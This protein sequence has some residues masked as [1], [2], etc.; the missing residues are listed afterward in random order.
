MPEDLGEIGDKD[1]ADVVEDEE[2]S[3]CQEKDRACKAN[4]LR[5][6]EIRQLHEY[7]ES[8][9]KEENLVYTIACESL[10][11]VHGRI[12]RL[13]HYG[14]VAIERK[15]GQ[16]WKDALSKHNRYPVVD[17]KGDKS[18]LHVQFSAEQFSSRIYITRIP[19][20]YTIESEPY[21]YPQSDIVVSSIPRSDTLFSAYFSLCKE[22]KENCEAP[23]QRLFKKRG[24]LLNSKSRQCIAHEREQSKVLHGVTCSFSSVCLANE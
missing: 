13:P 2:D 22:C 9:S 14:A 15:A 18:F 5:A 4:F 17:I 20:Q 24:Y 7:I 11:F 6:Q 19:N 1:E 12:K 16:A 10:A 8:V 21:D 23:A 3:N